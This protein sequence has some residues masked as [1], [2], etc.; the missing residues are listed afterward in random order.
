MVS[1]MSVVPTGS[2]GSCAGRRSSPA[3]RSCRRS[4]RPMRC[5]SGWGGVSCR[6]SM[7]TTTTTTAAAAAATTGVRHR[8][9]AGAHEDREKGCRNGQSF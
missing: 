7:T 1:M 5:G 6:P 4:K 8:R 3:R 9:Q 2:V